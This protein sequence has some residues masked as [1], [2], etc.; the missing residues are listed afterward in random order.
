[1]YDFGKAAQ[2]RRTKNPEGKTCAKNLSKHTP[3]PKGCFVGRC[4]PKQGQR[5][6]QGFKSLN[7]KKGGNRDLGKKAGGKNLVVL[8]ANAWGQNY[9][10]HGDVG[11]KESEG[12]RTNQETARSGYN[13]G[14]GKLQRE[15]TK[16]NSRQN[17]T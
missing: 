8:F 11:R 9:S 13:S 12:E 17:N 14:G 3:P 16:R 4:T 6:I 7:G 2:P 10:P 1:V 15:K 5:K